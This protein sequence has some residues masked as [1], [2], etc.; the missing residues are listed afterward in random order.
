MQFYWWRKP[1]YPEKTTPTCRKS[2]TNYHI[3]LYPSPWSRFELTT[4]VVTDTDCIGSCKSNYH[5]ITATTDQT[6]H[7]TVDRSIGLWCHVTYDI[8]AKIVSFC[9]CGFRIARFA[10]LCV[11]FCRSLFVLFIL[12]QLYCLSCF[13]F[14]ITPLLS[15]K[16]SYMTR[17]NLQTWDIKFCWL[18][19][20]RHCD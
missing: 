4:S 2:L 16:S 12:W 14:L 15:S 5:T 11:V 17:R 10:V 7:K 6:R 3:M 19:C 20:W 8:A 13:W 9:C 18:N 1:E